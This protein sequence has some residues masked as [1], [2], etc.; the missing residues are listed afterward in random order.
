M[1][2][3]SIYQRLCA[4][5]EKNP[6]SVTEFNNITVDTSEKAFINALRSL[7]AGV[8]VKVINEIKEG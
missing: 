1:T 6:L 7:G 2:I 4:D 3:Y 5:L 8:C